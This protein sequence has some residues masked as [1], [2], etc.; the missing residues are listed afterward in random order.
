MSARI[1]QHI[2]KKMRSAYLTGRIKAL[3]TAISGKF[4]IDKTKPNHRR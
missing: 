3:E 2:E 4:S 1:V